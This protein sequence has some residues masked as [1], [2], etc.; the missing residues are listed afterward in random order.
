MNNFQIYKYQPE[1]KVL[2]PKQGYCKRFGM[3]ERGKMHTLKGTN[4]QH[5]SQTG[6]KCKTQLMVEIYSKSLVG[7]IGKVLHL[8]YS[9][10]TK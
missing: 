4:T 8:K 5:S 7:A 9:Q 1:I 3:V 10:N 6:Q 2:F